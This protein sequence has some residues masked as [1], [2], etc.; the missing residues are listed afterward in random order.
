MRA[1]AALVVSSLTLG[2]A[3]LSYARTPAARLPVVAGPTAAR[4]TPMSVDDARR[5]V[6]MLSD[7][8]RESLLDL[9]VTYVHDGMPPSATV[10]KQLFARMTAKGWPVARWMSV[11]GRPLNPDNVPHN[12]WELE[13]GRQVRHGGQLV[14]RVERGQY[15][16]LVAV[17]FTGPCLKCHWGDQEADYRG[18]ISFTVPVLA[19]AAVKPAPARR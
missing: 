7:F 9:H 10:I 18:A 19:A 5:S 3:E 2:A 6:Q 11:N 16:A 14:E 13:A 12:R 15:Q 4:S 17:P 1:A 8:Y